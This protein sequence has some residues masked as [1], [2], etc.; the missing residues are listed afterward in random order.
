MLH[1]T[2]DDYFALTRI[3]KVI[4]ENLCKI[5]TKSIIFLTL[6]SPAIAI[7]IDVKRVRQNLTLIQPYNV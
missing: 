6:K 7:G 2:I 5:P 4:T 3:Y 1:S